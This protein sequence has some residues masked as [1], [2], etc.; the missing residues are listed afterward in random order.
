MSE[1]GLW[2][3]TCNNMTYVDLFS[4]PDTALDSW[5]VLARPAWIFDNIKR[6]MNNL[7]C[8]PYLIPISTCLLSLDSTC[9]HQIPRHSCVLQESWVKRLVGFGKECISCNVIIIYYN[10]VG[11]IVV[12]HPNLFVFYFHFSRVLWMNTGCMVRIFGTPAMSVISHSV[13]RATWRHIR[14]YTV[15]SIH[16]AVMCV[17]RHLVLRGIW[18]HIN[19][20]TGG[21][22]H[23]FVLCAISLLSRRVIWTD[24]Y[25]YIAGIVHISVLC[26]I[27]RLFRRVVWKDT[28][29]YTAA[30]IRI[31]V[32]CVVRH[33]V[34]RAFGRDTNSC[35]FKSIRILVTCAASRSIGRVFWRCMWWLTWRQTSAYVVGEVHLLVMCMVSHSVETANWRHMNTYIVQSI[36]IFV[37]YVRSPSV[38]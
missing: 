24:T 35:I 29:A 18:R 13:E 20:D 2:W 11:C 1:L 36:H 16:I 9:T 4:Q 25:G 8:F 26:V 17:V 5:F 10:Y 30:S 14:T 21:S 32:T 12:A 31:L 37:L 28:C 6:L 23:V 3:W 15:G 7:Y 33:S 27:S 22:F 38:L 19:A 34:I